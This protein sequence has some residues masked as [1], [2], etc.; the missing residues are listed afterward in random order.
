MRLRQESWLQI[1]SFTPESRR[2]GAM[3]RQLFQLNAFSCA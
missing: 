3:P 2:S 1:R